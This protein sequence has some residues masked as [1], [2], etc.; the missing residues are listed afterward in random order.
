M[1]RRTSSVKSRGSAG[2]RYNVAALPRRDAHYVNTMT[3]GTR[4]ESR[5]RLARQSLVYR[6]AGMASVDTMRIK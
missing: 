3:I 6:V 1:A 2:M 5:H 4:L